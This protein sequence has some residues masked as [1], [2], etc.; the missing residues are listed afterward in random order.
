MKIKTTC[1]RIVGLSVIAGAAWVPLQV[2][3]ANPA[4]PAATARA[5]DRTFQKVSDVKRGDRV[6]LRGEI[7][8]ILD[9]D[10]FVLTDDSGRIRIYLGGQKDVD[11]L[12]LNRGDTVIVEGRA[13]DD[14]IFGLRPEIYARV[15]E[16]TD[17]TRIDV[18][19]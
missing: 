11:E 17:G 8:R 2:A 10:E 13:D 1:A 19:R 3:S 15:I 12:D 9:E 4:A 14:T 16:L 7:T 6:T 18:K 5:E